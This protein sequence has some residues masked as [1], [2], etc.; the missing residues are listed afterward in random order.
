MAESGTCNVMC[1][2]LVGVSGTFCLLTR[3]RSHY[4]YID[5]NFSLG[6]GQR[7]SPRGR[8]RQRGESEVRLSIFRFIK[9]RTLLPGQRHRVLGSWRRT[10][11]YQHELIRD[12][13]KS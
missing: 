3:I 4:Q 13:A 2:F 7:H 10:I 1:W 9:N 11:D 8:G 12:R 6:F 5:K